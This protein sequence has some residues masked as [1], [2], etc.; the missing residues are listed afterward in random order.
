MRDFQALTAVIFPISLWRKQ[1][2]YNLTRPHPY[3]TQSREEQ[4]RVLHQENV[5][6]LIFLNEI[7]SPVL[8]KLMLWLIS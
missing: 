7:V 8:I 3:R 6:S 1:I 4:K 2:Y 5:S